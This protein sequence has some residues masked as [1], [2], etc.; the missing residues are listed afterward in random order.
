MPG[1]SMLHAF[2]PRERR[3]EREPLVAVVMMAMVLRTCRTEDR[4]S[5]D[6]IRLVI[7]SYSVHDTLD[8]L[9]M[10]T[11][12]FQ[13]ELSL[14]SYQ[15]DTMTEGGLSFAALGRVKPAFLVEF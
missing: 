5:K 3:G 7:L 8:G 15:T 1:P 14:L 6:H 2:T 13:N 9:N 11:Y 10:R 12:C 4:W